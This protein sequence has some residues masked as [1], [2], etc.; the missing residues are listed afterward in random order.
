MV[1]MLTWSP[2]PTQELWRWI[3]SAPG[4][5]AGSLNTLTSEPYLTL[6]KKRKYISKWWYTDYRPP[7]RPSVRPQVRWLGRGAEGAAPTGRPWGRFRDS[8]RGR[9]LLSPFASP[10]SLSPPLPPLDWL[11]GP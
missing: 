6:L 8:W 3:R 1:L 5:E 2:S 10:L 9:F 4:G 7:A 11:T